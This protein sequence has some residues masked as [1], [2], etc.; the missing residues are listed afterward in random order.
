MFFLFELFVFQVFNLIRDANFNNFLENVAYGCRKVLM[1]VIAS[2]AL[3]FA[4]VIRGVAFFSY[5]ILF[6]FVRI[7]KKCHRIFFLVFTEPSS[8]EPLL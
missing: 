2:R 3:S 7:K 1:H 8:S 6:V 5:D 4:G